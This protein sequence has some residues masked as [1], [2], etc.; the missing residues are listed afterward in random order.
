MGEREGKAMEIG[1][2]GRAQFRMSDR[3]RKN[4][5]QSALRGERKIQKSAARSYLVE[6]R[7]TYPSVIILTQPCRVIYSGSW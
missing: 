5:E 1:V 7:P 2:P 4:R 3:A 6:A